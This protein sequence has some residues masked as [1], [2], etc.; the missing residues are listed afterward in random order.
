MRKLGLATAAIAI[1]LAGA[2]LADPI[3]GK[4][5]TEDGPV[6]AIAACGAAFCITGTGKDAGKKAGEMKANGDGTYAG[7]ITR[8]KNGK[9]YSGKAVLSGDALKVSGC[10]LGGLFCESQ[11]WHRL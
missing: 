11:T 7:T 4:W 5:Q 9:T 2:A 6:A 1:I 10:V 8:P 3:E